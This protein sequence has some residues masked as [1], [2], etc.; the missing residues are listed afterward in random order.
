MVAV[1]AAAPLALLPAKFAWEAVRHGLGEMSEKENIIISVL[2]VTFCYLNA[3]LLPNVGAVISVIGATVQPFVGY[4]FPILFYLKI[5]ESPY[6]SP[7][8]IFALT[9]LIA[10]ILV[11]FLGFIALF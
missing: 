2:M 10:V 6:L 11:S 1:I 7:A 9:V 3:I 4:I 5:D 8:K